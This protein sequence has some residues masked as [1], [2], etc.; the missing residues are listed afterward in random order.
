MDKFREEFAEGDELLGKILNMDTGQ[1]FTAVRCVSRGENNGGPLQ[2]RFCVYT[3]MVNINGSNCLLEMSMP[4]DRMIDLESIGTHYE[5][6]VGTYLTLDSGNRTLLFTVGDAV[7]QEQTLEE[8]PDKVWEQAEAVLSRYHESGDS[9]AYYPTQNQIDSLPGSQFTC[10]TENAYVLAQIRRNTIVYLAIMLLFVFTILV[11]SYAVGTMLTIR[12]TRSIE[13][14]NNELDTILEKPSVAVIHESDFEGIERRIRKLIRNVQQYYVQIEQYEEEK[15]RLELELLQMRFNPH[16]LYNTLTSISYQ[17]EDE[18]IRGSIQSLIHYYRIVLSKGYLVIHIEEE[19][20]MIREY[21]ELQKFAYRLENIK[22]VFEI[23]EAVN[24]FTIVKHLLQPI[25][26]NALEHGLRVMD[27]EGTIWI[28]AWLVGDEILFE[29]E[30]NGAGMTKEQI[31]HVLSEP[32]RGSVGGGYGIY[33]VQQRIETYYGSEYGIHF[34]SKPGVGTKAVIR[35][36]KTTDM[37]E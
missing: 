22:F 14:M 16:F 4:I 29:I 33:N 31:L 12:V 6:I 25:V 17:T 5:C 28:R 15:N 24:S 32:A 2:E 11:C 37:M 3:K 8:R 30:D 20:A 1:V 35:I 19:I 13:K 23:D 18:R 9:E 10:L 7:R 27:R 34:T 26:E 36:P 21:L